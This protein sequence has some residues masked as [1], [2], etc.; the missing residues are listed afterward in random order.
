MIHAV[1]E[2]TQSAYKHGIKEEDIR[3]EV[4]ELLL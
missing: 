4:Q 3:H 1:I 2:Y